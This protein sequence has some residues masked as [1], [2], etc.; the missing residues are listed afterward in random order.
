MS[1]GNLSGMY[2]SSEAIYVGYQSEVYVQVHE[3]ALQDYE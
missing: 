2:G 1:Y 3:R